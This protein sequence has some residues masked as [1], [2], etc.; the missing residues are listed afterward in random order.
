MAETDDKVSGIPEGKKW[1]T[2]MGS[3]DFVEWVKR[4]FYGGSMDECEIPQKRNWYPTSLGL[5]AWLLIF[6][7]LKS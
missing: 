2:F 1:Q 5:S 7:R 4:R 6:T 3:S